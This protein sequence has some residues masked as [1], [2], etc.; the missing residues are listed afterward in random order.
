MGN[1]YRAK[2]LL[3]KKSALLNQP[4]GIVM[5]QTNITA[6]IIVRQP[7]A[8]DSQSAPSESWDQS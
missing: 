8:S 4:V 7:A 6:F 3:G 5:G 1:N 2:T